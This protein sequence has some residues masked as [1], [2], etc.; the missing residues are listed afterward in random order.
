MYQ[1]RKVWSHATNTYDVAS[2][3]SICRRPAL[4][5]GS[6]LW[7]EVQ[8]LRRLTVRVYCKSDG[9]LF[10]SLEPRVRSTSFNHQQEWYFLVNTNLLYTADIYPEHNVYY[11]RITFV[12]CWLGLLVHQ[13]QE[14][15]WYGESLLLLI[16]GHYSY[17]SREF[18]Y[19]AYHNSQVGSFTLH[20]KLS[21]KS[22]EF[23]TVP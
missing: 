11:H 6:A 22:R 7:E 13:V 15:T 9:T 20:W 18:L 21:L 5:S 23:A 19:P 2:I 16:H 1:E 14:G 17:L 12:S 3:I 8:I 10:F 4:R